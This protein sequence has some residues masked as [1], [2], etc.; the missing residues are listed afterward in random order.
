[1]NSLRLLAVA[2]CVAVFSSCS[3][4]VHMPKGSSRGYTSARTVKRAPNASAITSSR[5]KSVHNLIQGNIKAQFKARGMGYNAPDADLV[6]GYM[7]VY[8][9]NS[10][11]TSF[12]DYFGYG[13]GGSEILDQ[14]HKKGVIEG[15]RADYF[16]RAGLIVDVIDA[17]TNKLIFRNVSVGDIVNGATDAQRKQAIANAVNEALVPFFK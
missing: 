10:M 9:N 13:R 2:A 1:M 14:A 5:E 4:S 8:Q 17:K 6:V 12:D 15:N 16:E 7:V 3:S 11:T